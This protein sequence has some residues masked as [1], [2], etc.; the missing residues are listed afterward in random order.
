MAAY[1]G[2]VIAVRDVCFFR[3]KLVKSEQKCVC[4]G[5]GGFDISWS[6]FAAP[7]CVKCYFL[8]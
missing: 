6:V 3:R 2:L 8:I 7:L 4:M 5:G 1:I